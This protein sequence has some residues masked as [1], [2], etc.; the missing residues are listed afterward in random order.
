MVSTIL[1]AQR[2][3]TR[4]LGIPVDGSKTEMLRKLKEKGFVSTV[5]D[6]EML[7]GEFNGTEV[8]VHVVTNNDK[9]WRIALSDVNCV[10]ET[11]I[12]LRFNKLCKQFKSNPK[13]ISLDDYTI[14]DEED[15]S[16]EI[17]VHD[18]R[19]EAVF[20]QQINT[21]D[22]LAIAN[23]IK[24]I[25]LQKYTEEELADLKETN[26]KGEDF[27]MQMLPYA[28]ELIQKKSV[29]FMISKNYDE[30]RITMYYDN[31]YNHANGEDL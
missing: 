18:K 29:W 6:E 16:Y 13:Y 20:Y 14:S 30:Y 23:A 26:L 1:F 3:V 8:Y 21:Q 17:T 25:L 27:I 2:D 5:I 9:V 11:G 10:S 12:R 15:I 19:Y 31:E 24:E 7:K 4:F 22:T 28:I